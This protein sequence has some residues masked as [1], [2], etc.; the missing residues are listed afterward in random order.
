MSEKVAG[1]FAVYLGQK[2]IV[3]FSC[4]CLL[5]DRFGGTRHFQPAVSE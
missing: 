1:R 2:A 5:F 3:W 4:L